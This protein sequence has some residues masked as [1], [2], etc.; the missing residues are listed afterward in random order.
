M[1]R[2]IRREC[3]LGNTNLGAGNRFLER[4]RRVESAIRD[5]SHTL[6]HVHLLRDPS[7]FEAAT[8]DHSVVLDET[9]VGATLDL[10]ECCAGH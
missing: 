10:S 4:I 1:R 9:S 8:R 2:Y 5:L 7:Q 3:T 6:A